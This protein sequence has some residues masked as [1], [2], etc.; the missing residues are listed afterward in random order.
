MESNKETQ[1]SNDKTYLLELVEV[2]TANQQR[3]VTGGVKSCNV[4]RPAAVQSQT[5]EQRVRAEVEHKMP[6]N[7]S[8]KND[9]NQ[10]SQQQK[11]ESHSESIYFFR[12]RYAKEHI[13]QLELISKRPA[14]T[15]LCLAHS[16]DGQ[17]VSS[18]FEFIKNLQGYKKGDKV[19]GIKDLKK[20]LERFGYLNPNP[21]FDDQFDDILESAIK[22]YQL[23]FN[24]NTTGTLDPQTVSTMMMPRCGMPDIINGIYSIAII[25]VLIDVEYN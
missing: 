13:E 4:W 25:Y 11:E 23:N 16:F 10:Q 21:S 20:Y 3:L 12:T 8:G 6:D 15:K 5:R 19:E 7:Q 22:T 14:T 9:S 1:N 18:Q 2:R 24:L 17:Q